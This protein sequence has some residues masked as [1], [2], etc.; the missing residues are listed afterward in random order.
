MKPKELPT[1]IPEN[2]PND[3][4]AA[5]PCWEPRFSSAPAD[6]DDIEMTV[7]PPPFVSLVKQRSPL[8]PHL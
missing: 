2:L 8:P 1:P 6:D 3:E 5:I 7:V 4:D